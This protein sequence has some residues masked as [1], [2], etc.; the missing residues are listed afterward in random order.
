M[1]VK[2][3][4]SIK[5][6]AVCVAIMIVVLVAGGSLTDLGPWYQSLKLPTWQPPGPAFGIIWTTIYV[7]TTVSAI[8]VWRTISNPQK[9]AKL[10]GLFAI[11]GVLNILWSLLFFKLQRPDWALYQVGFFWLSILALIIFIWLRHKIASALLAPYIIWV[12]IASYL[13][14]SIVKLNGPFG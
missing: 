14:L 11:N 5:S 8:L 13:N 3:P 7:L 1:S 12:S 4:L 10:I 9:G 6:I 2:K